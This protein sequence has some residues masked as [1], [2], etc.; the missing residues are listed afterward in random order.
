MDRFHFPP[1]VNIFTGMVLFGAAAGPAYLGAVVFYGTWP[2]VMNTGYG[3]DQPV[4][5]SHKL[6]AGELKMDCRYCHST[7]DKTAHAAVP[8]TSTCGNCHSPKLADGT[9]AL[10]ALHTESVKLAPVR[11]SLVT[12]KPVY[13]EKVHDLADY[14]YFNHSAHVNRGVSCVECHGRIDRMEVVTQV[15]SLS[16]SYCLE[17]H[18]NPAKRLQPIDQVTNLAWGDDKSDSE[19]QQFGEEFIDLKNINASTNCS[20]CHR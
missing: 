8:A 3:P 5:F 11:E 20:T 9:T 1:W 14:V 2:S 15:K 17:C 13:W 12:G 10:T 4:P 19:R 18:R 16:M 7:V 6:H